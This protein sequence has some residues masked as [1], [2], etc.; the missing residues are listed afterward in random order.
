M[1][2]SAAMSVNIVIDGYNVIRQSDRLIDLEAVSLEKGRTGLIKMLA[3][4]RK[5]KRHS[6]TVIFDGWESDNIGSSS[7]I[8]QGIDIIYSG[9]GE[10]ADDL[11]K[12]MADKL[13]DKI[14]VVTSDKDIATHVLR[15]GAV[16]IPS[17]EFEMKLLMAAQDTDE[18]GDYADEEDDEPRV[19]GRKKGPARRRSKEEI[20]KKG[21]LDKL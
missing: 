16:V 5:L 9:R 18:Y 2:S 21:K 10:K 20:R 8:L 13:R 6:I 14:V 17:P 3:E 15:K 19:G 12:K 1:L 7:E 11:I 4:Y